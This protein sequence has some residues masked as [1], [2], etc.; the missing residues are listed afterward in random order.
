MTGQALDAVSAVPPDNDNEFSVDLEIQDKAKVGRDGEI[1]E[2]YFTE[3]AWPFSLLSSSFE[4]I[5]NTAE[6]R[7]KEGW[8]GRLPHEDFQA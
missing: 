1:S 7:P 2:T 5:L 4:I 3:L 8:P 6:E